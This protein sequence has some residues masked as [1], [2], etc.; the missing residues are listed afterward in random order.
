M[1][2]G[3]EA[4]N[5]YGAGLSRYLRSVGIDVREVLRPTRAQRHHHGKSDPLDAL[6]A[7]RTVLSDT[8][9][10]T[11]KTSDGPVESIRILL[12]T[13]DSALKARTAVM[14]QIKMVLVSAPTRIREAFT[15]LSDT[16]LLDTLRR[17]RPAPT[18][19]TIETTTLVVL[20]RLARRHRYLTE[21]IAE[22]TAELEHL[23]TLTAPALIATPGVG[24]VTAAQLLATVGDNPE[25]ITSEAA[26]AAL[27]GTSPIPA[28]SGKITRHRLNRGGDRRANWAIHQIALVR[29]SH[30]QRT[31]DYLDK[32]RA[33]GKTTRE[34]IRC[35][36]RI[37][38]REI[39]KTLTNPP[40][41]PDTTDLRPLRH[42]RGL[43][44]QNA[45]DHF[46][47]W[48]AHISAIERGTRRDDELAHRYRDWLIRQPGLIAA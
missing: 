26:F 35:L 7:A 29:S 12:L 23:V 30:D 11:P 17:T 46:Q 41:V 24:V 28:S 16:A 42:A 15:E 36:K 39:Y 14:Q 6:A 20:R 21:E 43:T 25:R 3:I 10:P 47:V 38:A 1:G 34:A 19:T 32:K 9:L 31:K 4:T 22:T 48:P 44:L 27:T 45:A 18:A 40:A 2:F 13:R 5:S 33:E 37:I 8:H